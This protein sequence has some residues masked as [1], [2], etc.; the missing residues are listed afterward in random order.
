[1][2][3][4][5][6]L[7]MVLADGTSIEVTPDGSGNWLSDNVQASMLTSENLRK[8]YITGEKTE[9]QLENQVCEG[10]Y[11]YMGTFGFC[12]RDKTPEEIIQETLDI[13]AG[14]IAELAEM[15]GG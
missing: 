5:E 3:N 1:M 4:E 14:A 11:P 12:L 8:V 15:I 9:I 7:T 13:Y 6:K 2:A 10:I